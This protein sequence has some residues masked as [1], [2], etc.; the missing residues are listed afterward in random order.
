MHKIL[1][2]LV[3]AAL[4]AGTATAS[5]KSDAVGVLHQ[6]ADAFNKSDM[7]SALAICADVTSIIDDVPPHEWHGAGACSRWSGDLDAFNKANEVT[8]AAVT[9]GKPRHI[10][11]T[12]EHAYIVVPVSYIFTMKSKPM[13][14]SGSILTAVLQKGAS[15]WRLSAWSWSDGTEIEVK[16]GA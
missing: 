2:V 6:F 15:G 7:K 11:I 3:L 1:F 14:Q 5:D 8:G 10:D 16:P 4:G 12:A 13:K 9:I